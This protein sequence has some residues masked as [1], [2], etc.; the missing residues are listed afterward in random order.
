LSRFT[1]IKLCFEP[2]TVVE[3]N[4]RC[5][6]LASFEREEVVRILSELSG[7][8]G[9]KTNGLLVLVDATA[10]LDL[11][12]ACGALSRRWRGAPVE[13]ADEVRLLGARHPLLPDETVVPIDLDLGDLRAL[14]V[15]GP[16]TGG[17]TVALK[18]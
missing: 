12:L 13:V 2:F 10:A 5:T 8:V 11:S 7:L 16:N 9:A 3:S 1:T 6:E 17:K 4:N 14:V 18:T 15:S